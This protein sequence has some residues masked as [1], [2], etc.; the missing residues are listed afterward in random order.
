MIINRLLGLV[1]EKFKSYQYLSQYIP[2]KYRGDIDR[3]VKQFKPEIFE[4][5]DEPISAEA[6]DAAGS[7][8][9]NNDEVEKKRQNLVKNFSNEEGQFPRG[10][11]DESHEQSLKDHQAESSFSASPVNG[12]GNIGG[13]VNSNMG[14]RNYQ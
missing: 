8:A 13:K 2:S 11:T 10:Y 7:E 1:P 3:I 9:L 4:N 12:A 14:H 6:L 5:E